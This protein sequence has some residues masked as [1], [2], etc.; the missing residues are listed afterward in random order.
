MYDDHLLLVGQILHPKAEFTHGQGKR[1]LGGRALGGAD[2]TGAGELG[3]QLNVT[4]TKRPS[5]ESLILFP[6]GPASSGVTLRL[7]PSG[8]LTAGDHV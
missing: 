4:F 2:G 3:S 8:R 7:A 1:L 6:L 5:R